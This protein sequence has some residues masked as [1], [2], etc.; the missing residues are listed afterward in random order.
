[1]G[2]LNAPPTA[3]TTPAMSSTLCGSNTSGGV[4]IILTN[5]TTGGNPANISIQ[6]NAVVN[7]TAPTSGTY[8]GL[9]FFQNRTICSGNTNACGNTLGGGSTQ[10]IQ[11][12]IY[13]P[14]NAVGYNGGASS[15]SL[16][17]TCTQLI[18]YQLSFQGNSNLASSCASAGTAKI[19]VTGS[20]LVE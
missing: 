6:A 17:A 12:A 1:G 8:S 14:K 2:V 15:G 5:S 4:T 18:A 11:G 19:N 9:A 3:N 20:H 13:F 16:A 10:N 7:V